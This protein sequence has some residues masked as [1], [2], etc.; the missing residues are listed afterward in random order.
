[1]AWIYLLIASV[2]EVIF[3]LGTNATDGF[4]KLVPSLITAVAAG[5][6]IFFL[7]LA[8]K[9]LDVGVGYAIWTGIGSVGT[10]LLGTVIF[11]ES[12][13]LGKVICFV[14]ILGGIIGLKLVDRGSAEAEATTA[15]ATAT[16]PE[17]VR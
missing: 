2:F 14:A 8:L 17:P 16:V 15:P 4:T 11:D 13:N 6:G 12:L 3:A 10:V 7:S 9:T 5:F 1:M